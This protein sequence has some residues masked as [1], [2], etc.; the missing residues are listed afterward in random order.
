[1]RGTTS[2]GRAQPS[3][4][5]SA[6][7]QDYTPTPV[8]SVDPLPEAILLPL[9]D[10]HLMT[11]SCRKGGSTVKLRNKILPPF[12][13]PWTSR[14]IV[15]IPA[16]EAEVVEATPRD[17]GMLMLSWNTC[18]PDEAA[19]RKLER[20]MAVR[21]ELL[22]PSTDWF[23]QKM[24]LL[25]DCRTLAKWTTHTQTN[26]RIPTLFGKYKHG[27]FS[28]NKLMQGLSMECIFKEFKVLQNTVSR[29]TI[30]AR[31]ILGK[32]YFFTKPMTLLKAKNLIKPED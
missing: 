15:R 29:T 4:I 2:K 18:R 17:I 5:E 11:G 13:L 1:M 19:S 12:P 22:D 8:I 26:T 28:H 20:R 10:D 14:R 21:S 30:R 9:F 7:L 32:R 16:W 24:K 3:F 27:N 23:W 6:T 25:F 31:L